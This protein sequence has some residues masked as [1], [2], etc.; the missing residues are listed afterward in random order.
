MKL[1]TVVIAA[2]ALAGAAGAASSALANATI[3]EE[4]QYTSEGGIDG[5]YFSVTNNSAFT[6]TDVKI[7]GTDLGNLAAGASTS[8][9][10][11]GEPTY[12]GGSALIT[13]LVNGHT[14]DAVFTENL[15][16]LDTNSS[17]VEL[18]TLTVPEPATWALMLTGFAGLG[19]A[20]RMRRKAPIAV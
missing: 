17:P 6:Y 20:L 8:F 3:F 11:V 4:Y 13:I 7:G 9:V 18:G 15:G 12:G 1:T 19:A 10:G 5:D 16:D 2:A 14:A